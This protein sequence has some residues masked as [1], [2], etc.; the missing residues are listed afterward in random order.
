M[1]PGMLVWLPIAAAPIII[2]L[3]NRRRY[4]EHHWAAM[5]YLLAA[6]KKSSRRMRIEQLLLLLLRTAIILLLVLAI[7]RP[8]LN[9]IG[10]SIVGGP[11]THRVLVIDGSYSM[12]YRPAEDNLFEMAKKKAVEIV[13][14]SNEGDGFSLVL[15]SESPRAIISTAAFSRDDV[16]EEIEN[17]RLPHGSAALLPAVRSVDAIVGSVRKDNPRLT[18]NHVYFFSDLGLNTWQDSAMSAAEQAELQD[19]LARL[20]D[21]GVTEVIPLGHSG[22]SNL[23][24]TDLRIVESYA[25]VQRPVSIEAVIGSWGGSETTRQIVELVVDGTRV[26]QEMVD[27]R[28]GETSTP[29]RFNYQFT[30]PGDHTIEVRIPGD[31]LNVDNH[32]YLALPVREY[33]RALCVS[34]K[35]DSALHVVLGLDPEHGR[36]SA[37]IIQPHVVSESGLLDSDLSKYDCI[38]LCNVAQFTTREAAVLEAQVKRGAGLVF[39]LGDQVQAERYN[40]ELSQASGAAHNV[41]PVTLK[42]TV[43]ANKDARFFYFDPLDYRHAMLD[44]WKNNE[45]AGL[46]KTPVAKYFQLAI[47]DAAPDESSFETRV[48]LAFDNGDP[49]IV[50]GRIGNGRVLV[51]ATAGSQASVMQQEE[52]TRPWT[53]MPTSPTFPVIVQQLWQAA[54]A[55]RLQERNVLVFEAFGGDLSEAGYD[56]RVQVELPAATPLDPA[57]PPPVSITPDSQAATWSFANTERSGIYRASAD[58]LAQTKTYAANVN[59]RESDLSRINPEELPLGFLARDSVTDTSDDTL[60][61]EAPPAPAHQSILWLVMALVFSEVSLAWWLGNRQI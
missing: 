23:A 34:G 61:V 20:S 36:S 51:V 46:L 40:R 47:P 21:S 52:G 9:A 29:V 3:W 49:A 53:M 58:S 14:A 15:M 43:E 55:G 27:V 57:A 13:Q 6:I 33:V 44:V 18:Q 59:T 5:E 32:R 4:R 38:F 42:E 24:V 54:V 11:R 8:V 45:R 12:D 26:D 22:V 19:A 48:A 41:L 16:I 17:L 31:A 30:S 39:F 56:E 35:Q 25:T 2:H 7:A 28:P 1:N 50:E 10:A 60:A 37:S